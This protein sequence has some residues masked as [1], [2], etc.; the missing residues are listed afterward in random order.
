MFVVIIII[1]TKSLQIKGVTL[2]QGLHV[3]ATEVEI[4][5]EWIRPYGRSV[6]S[7]YDWSPRILRQNIR[8][9]AFCC[10]F[11][12]S[13]RSVE[14]RPEPQGR[15]RTAHSARCRNSRYNSNQNTRRFR[16]VWSRTPSWGYWYRQRNCCRH[17]CRCRSCLRHS[18]HRAA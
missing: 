8:C 9:K 12:T 17:H 11:R 3:D 10:C 1:V 5:S 16:C 4:Y 14:T 13:R 6:M 15:W 2:E 18:N 7:V